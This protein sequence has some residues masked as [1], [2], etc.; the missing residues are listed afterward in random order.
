[1]RFTRLSGNGAAAWADAVDGGRDELLNPWMVII[2]GFVRLT[3]VTVTE[4]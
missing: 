1:M 4:A 3:V 2:L